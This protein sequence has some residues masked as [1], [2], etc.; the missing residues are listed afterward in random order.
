MSYFRICL[1]QIPVRDGN[2]DISCGKKCRQAHVTP[3][4]SRR[5]TCLDNACI[6]KIFNKMKVEIGNLK[7]YHSPESLI[8]AIKTWIKYYN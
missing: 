8:Q 7:Q 1:R 4:M 6:E 2:T 3:S 5:A